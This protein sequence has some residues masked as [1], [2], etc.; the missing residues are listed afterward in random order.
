MGRII[1]SSC[2]S[3]YLFWSNRTLFPLFLHLSH[4]ETRE[5]E[6]KFIEA[7]P[8]NP[9]LEWSI[10]IQPSFLFPRKVSPLRNTGSTL[11]FQFICLL[12]LLKISSLWKPQFMF[13]LKKF[14]YSFN[15]NPTGIIFW[16]IAFLVFAEVLFNREW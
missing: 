1:V 10:W 12:F 8:K 14:I 13:F 3:N 5:Y 16:L 9:S 2:S 6:V 15:E 4:G 11:Q 7:T